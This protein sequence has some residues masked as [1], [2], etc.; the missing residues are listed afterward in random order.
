MDAS[1]LK[2]IQAVIPAERL[3]LELQDRYSYSFDASFGEYLPEI[4]VQPLSKEEISSL[5]FWRIR[6]KSPY[7]P[8]DQPLR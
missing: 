2:E 1:V 4:V 7:I 6:T 3:F 5:S 8:A